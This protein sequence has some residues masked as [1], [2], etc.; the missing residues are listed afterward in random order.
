VAEI[1]VKDKESYNKILPK[2]LEMIKN[3]GGTYVAGA[4]P[5][6]LRWDR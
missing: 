2:A 4:Q 6:T 3:G 5:L 1:N